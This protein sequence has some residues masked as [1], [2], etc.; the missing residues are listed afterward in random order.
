MAKS[1]FF[2]AHINLIAKDWGENKMRSFMTEFLKLHS[3]YKFDSL[4]VDGLESL[5]IGGED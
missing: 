2:S 4:K 5:K 3:S 1:K